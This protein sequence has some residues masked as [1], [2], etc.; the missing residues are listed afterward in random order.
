[1]MGAASDFFRRSSRSFPSAS[2]SLAPLRSGARHDVLD[3]GAE[4][5]AEVVML[6]DGPEDVGPGGDGRLMVKPEGEPD[7]LERLEAQRSAIAMCRSRW[8]IATGMMRCFRATFSWM[9]SIAWGSTGCSSGR[10]WGCRAAGRGP[11][12]SPV[13]WQS[14]ADDHLPE[15]SPLRALL[16]QGSRKGLVVQEAGLERYSPSR[17]LRHFLEVLLAAGGFPADNRHPIIRMEG[18]ATGIETDPFPVHRKFKGREG[19]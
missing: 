17:F 19:K 5:R 10:S 7:I 18:S 9:S 15:F 2:G 6:V 8:S 1:M 3:D 11:G 13:P 4:G 16:P 12:R 14:E